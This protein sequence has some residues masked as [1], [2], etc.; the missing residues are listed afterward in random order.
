[1]RKSHDFRYTYIPMPTANE[2][3]DP[4][5]VHP[6]PPAE[7]Q[8]ARCGATWLPGADTCWLCHAPA[9]FAQ[10]RVSNEVA[11]AKP[12]P[13]DDRATAGSFSLASLMMAMTLVSVIFGISTFAPGVGIPLGVVL[14]VVWLKTASRA[15]KRRQLG[16]SLTW[17]ETTQLFFASFGDAMAMIAVVCAAGAAAFAV[18]CFVCATSFG[19]AEIGG[20]ALVGGILATVAVPLLWKLVRAIRNRWLDEPS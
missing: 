1:M 9:T 4:S 15:G 8:C 19:E 18:A 16:Q 14:L 20:I 5:N 17:A 6:T 10:A 3:L 7:A 11:P 2:P 12:A 13:L